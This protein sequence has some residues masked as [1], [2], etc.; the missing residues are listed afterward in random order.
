[1]QVCNEVGIHQWL[2]GQADYSEVSSMYFRDFLKNKYRNIKSL[3]ESY[4]SSYK[5][6]DDIPLPAGKIGSRTEIVR[7][8]D[9]HAYHR[10][11]YNRYLSHL[12]R[13]IRKYDIDLT[14]YHNVPGWVF[15]RALEFPV[16]IS[17]YT[18]LPENM[19]L[20]VDHIP[21]RV[22]FTNIHDDYIINQMV[23]ALQRRQY[24][25]FGA[26]LQ[27]GTREHNVRTFHNEMRLFYKACFAHGLKGMNY[28]MFCQGENPA[29]RGAYSHLFY[30][31][32]CL[33]IEA[34][35][36]PLYRDCR[37]LGDWLKE[38]G[39]ALV[40]SS[41]KAEIGVVFY[42]EYYS[43][44]F[45]YPLFGGEKRLHASDAGLFYDMKYA[46][47]RFYFET[48]L[49]ILKI[50]NIPFEI[51]IPDRSEPADLL[52][53]K[54]LWVFSLDSM[55]ET[56]QKRVLEYINGGGNAVIFPL[57]P[58][59]GKN[60][61]S[62]TVLMDALGITQKAAKN[63]KIPR[64]DV[65]G[66][67]GINVEGS[68]V[69]LASGNDHRKIAFLTE[70]DRCCG[71]EVKSGS[72]KASVLGAFFGY[73]T[74]E[75][76]D[77]IKKFCEY[78]ENSV[79]VHSSDSDLITVLRE[80]GREKILF[81]LNYSPLDVLSHIKIVSDAEEYDMGIVGV[82]A[83]SGIMCPIEKDI[84]NGVKL[85]LAS[86]E[87]IAVNKEEAGIK[88]CFSAEGNPNPVLEI[89]L[90]DSY[91][92]VCSVK[93]ETSEKGGLTKIKITEPVELFNIRIMR[94]G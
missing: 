58:Y 4:A 42:P 47:E 65:S 50:L 89:L 13:E 19:I 7:W 46:R 38:N 62:C 51:V 82:K 49:K 1:M 74:S 53:Y 60:L 31:E 87:I 80:N 33:D 22:S 79:K 67:S 24:P 52:K 84:K 90:P 94:G 28:Y 70:T 3:N 9:C 72:G 41:I 12:C 27:A 36:S 54:K 59:L 76:I 44:E 56:T 55:S 25:V 66:L 81:L 63:Y 30:W 40:E 10:D 37:Y 91:K 21:E 43:T 2:S 92:A 16:C 71:L 34:A 15:G 85:R 20:G 57:M 75:H 78:G 48:L 69:E 35:E 83:H 8:N 39:R 64:I 17:T 6:F 11:Y 32:N 23:E 61:E 5:G 26:E 29:G 73:Q 68:I 93:S 88:I 18:D 45:A 86:S 14:L 77:V